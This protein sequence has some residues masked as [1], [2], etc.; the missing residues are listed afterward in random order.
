MGPN[1]ELKCPK[2]GGVIEHD[3]TFDYDSGE[4]YLVN[5]CSGHCTKCDTEFLWEEI[6]EMKFSSIE[7]LREF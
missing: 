4:D 5:Q 7:D 2:C 6:F 1:Y 3:E